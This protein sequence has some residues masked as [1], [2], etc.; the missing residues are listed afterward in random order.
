MSPPRP[1]SIP[2]TLDCISLST[3]R[4]ASFTAAITRSCSISTSPL[5]TASGSILMASTCLRP[6][7]L[8]VT[9]PPPD[10]ASTTVCSI[11]FCSVS[12]C[13]F[14]CAMSSCKLNPDI[15]KVGNFV[16]LKF[17]NLNPKL[18][19][20][21]VGF[22]LPNYTITKLQ[23]YKMFLSFLPIID[24]G[25]N[26]RSELFFH[27]LHDRILFGATASA[28]IR[29]RTRRDYRLRRSAGLDHHF[30][31]PSSQTAGGGT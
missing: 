10:E 27:A 22:K 9:V 12:Y 29:G 18:A 14:A 5:L 8:T 31:R 13:C 7:I 19:P 24:H 30:D 11:F 1:P 6:S 26:F 28:S 15:G 20:P 3:L 2:P 25:P 17:G 21:S 4:L 16:I 23:N